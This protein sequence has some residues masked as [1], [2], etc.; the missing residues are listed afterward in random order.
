MALAPN[1]DQLADRRDAVVI[2]IPQAVAR[3]RAGISPPDFGRGERRGGVREFPGDNQ[4]GDGGI[5]PAARR[6]QI[7]VL[8]KRDLLRVR[9][10]KGVGLRFR[11]PKRNDRQHDGNKFS[12]H[13][14]GRK[15]AAQRLRGAALNS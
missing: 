1:L 6:E 10:R 15:C 3:D 14:E 8:L 12:H 2:A 4:L 11:I 7:P 13:A 9:Q 5:H